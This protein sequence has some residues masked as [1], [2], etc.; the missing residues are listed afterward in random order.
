MIDPTIPTHPLPIVDEDRRERNENRGDPNAER[1]AICFRALEA[2]AF[3]AYTVLGSDA[4]EVASFEARRD[5]IEADGAYSG[6]Y[7]L[8]SECGRKIP[9]AFRI[10]VN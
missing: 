4:V 2:P 5:E 6:T 7:Y 1:C 10:R 9:A 8:G 3:A